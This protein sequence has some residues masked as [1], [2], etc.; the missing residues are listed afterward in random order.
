MIRTGKVRSECWWGE[1]EHDKV[2]LQTTLIS[3]DY[4]KTI[5]K[6]QLTVTPMYPA[7]RR[8]PMAMRSEPMRKS[9][10]ARA[11]ALHG[12]FG[13]LFLNS[14]RTNLALISN[15]NKGHWNLIRIHL[16]KNLKLHL[17]DSE[18]P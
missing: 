16:L 8:E 18:L 5:T 3:C 11:M 15:S 14:R 17:N 13:G 9:T 10:A 2:K 6:T 7:I 1:G 4:V 12:T